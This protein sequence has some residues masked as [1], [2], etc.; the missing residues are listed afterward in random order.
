VIVDNT[1]PV[2]I[3]Q[4]PQPTAYDHSGSLA[5]DYGASDGV[6]SGVATVSATLDGAPAPASGTN[7]P[8]LTTLSL[9]TH[10]LRI[11]ATDNV[12][13]SS[14]ASVSFD[15]IATRAGIEREVEQL[16][17]RLAPGM[18]LTLGVAQ[19]ARDHGRCNIARAVYQAFIAQVRA[20]Q[21][22]R[23]IDPAAAQILIGDASYLIANC[24]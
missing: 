6:G 5:L 14:T 19:S 9:G 2:I 11:D 13:L 12:G 20:Q 7:I 18:K 8:L 21:A 23:R 16:G 24:P 1:P 4:Q 3:V 15:V 10:T 22:A 17:P